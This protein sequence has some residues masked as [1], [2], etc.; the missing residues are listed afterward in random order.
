MADRLRITAPSASADGRCLERGSPASRPGL[1]GL[2]QVE[3]DALGLEPSGI[4]GEGAVRP[5]DPMTGDDD[6]NRVAC[7]REPD[8]PRCPRLADTAGDLTIR[9]GLP[10]GDLAQRVPHPL[11]KAG[12]GWTQSDVEAGA[13]TGE[14]VME[15]GDNIGERCRVFHPM[16]ALRRWVG[17]SFHHQVGETVI[18]PGQGEQSDGAVDVAIAGQGHGGSFAVQWLIG[19]SWVAHRYW[20]A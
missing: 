2:L 19:W 17:R 18:L 20:T 8:G 16:V 14:V 9:A 13:L 7:V 10:V 1:A 11:L 3:Q 15:L 5:D 6:G 4:A 12:A